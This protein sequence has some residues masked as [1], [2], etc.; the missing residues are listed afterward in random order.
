MTATASFKA[1]KD[2]YFLLDRNFN[3][4]FAACTLDTQ[5]DELRAAYVNARDNFWEARNRSFHDDEPLV[6]KLI[7]DLKA[8]QQEIEDSLQNLEDIVKTLQ[9]VTAAVRLG[10]SLITMG[11]GIS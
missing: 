3:A 1:L 6:K 8:T 4:L 2:Q 9:L 7:A 5:R 11:S 10:S